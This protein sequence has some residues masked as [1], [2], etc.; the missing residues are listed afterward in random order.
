M[1]SMKERMFL[2]RNRKGKGLIRMPPNPL[3]ALG[4]MPPNPLRALGTMPPNPL[5]ALGRMRSLNVHLV[6]E[7]MNVEL[8]EHGLKRVPRSRRIRRS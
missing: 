8:E 5:R 4:T 3:R 6:A 2:R 7:K 1:E